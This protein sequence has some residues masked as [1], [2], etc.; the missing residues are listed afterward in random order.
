MKEKIKNLGGYFIGIIIFIG[1]I[2][3][4]TLFIKGGI[5]LSALIIPWLIVIS[6]YTLV[7]V[8]II[9]L[10]LSLI[11][12]TRS[13][14]SIGFMISSYIFG[15]TLWVWSF[16]LAYILWGFTGLFIGLTIAGVGVI[17]IAMLAS[18]FNAHWASFG[19]LLLL[20][21]MVFGFR[22]ISIYLMRKTES[23]E[24]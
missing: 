10:P 15:A 22:F 21:I 18:I 2:L 6:Q 5:K 17:P 19:Q 14:S 13:F 12:K 24:Y 23:A 8:I 20:T 11:R 4:I 16:L 1:L 3:L 9:L 7:I